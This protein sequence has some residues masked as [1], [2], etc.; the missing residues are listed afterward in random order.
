[1]EEQDDIGTLEIAPQVDEGEFL[2]WI[3]HEDEDL[4]VL[5]KPGWLVCHPSKNGPLSS[6]VGASKNYLGLDSIHLASRLDRE[7]SGVVLLAKNRKTAS[8]WQKGI[9]RKFVRRAYLAILDGVLVKE[10][11]VSGL[12]GNDPNSEVFVKQR[13]VTN[14]RKARFAQTTFSPLIYGESHTLCLVRTLTG[15]KHQIR[16]HAQYLGFPLVGEKL[17]G[18]DE[19]IYLR[20]CKQG[21]R[22]EWLDQIGMPRQA[23]HARFLL[24]TC[25]GVGFRAP[26][27]DDLMSFLLKNFELKADLIDELIDQADKIFSEESKNLQN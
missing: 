5:N 23:L 8:H 20:F 24:D 27:P 7:T 12:L 14:G 13:V 21:W 19:R 1:M 22:E 26:L 11:T 15:R 4:L 2:T 6:L 9:E 18:K 17:Y 16:V 10:E 3:L 25:S